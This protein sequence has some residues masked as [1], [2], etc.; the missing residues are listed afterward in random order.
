[1]L[2]VVRTGSIN[3]HKHRSMVEKQPWCQHLEL[4]MWANFSVIEVNEGNIVHVNVPNLQL[5]N[6]DTIC[7]T[8]NVKLK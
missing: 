2:W 7:A 3:I 5:P 1:M 6:S 8:F 4:W